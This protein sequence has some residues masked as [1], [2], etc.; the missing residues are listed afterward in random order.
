MGAISSATSL[1]PV[2]TSSTST[3]VTARCCFVAGTLVLMADGTVRALEAIVVGDCVIGA[4]GEVN[5]V[6]AIETPLLGERLLY[7]FNGGSGFVTPEHP[8]MTADGWKAIDPLQADLSHP[9]VPRVG[10]LGAGDRLVVLAGVRRC[11]LPV[12]V[13]AGNNGPVYETVC[14]TALVM[15]ET[16]ATH[17]GDPAQQVY[18]LRIDGNHAYFADGYLAHNK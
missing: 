10:T 3:S 1:V 17:D 15:I 13:G 6:Y 8:L 4:D 11:A 14:E 2:T 9:G 12:A 16:I 7:G 18:N 5:K